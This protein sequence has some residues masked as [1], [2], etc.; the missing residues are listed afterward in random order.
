M[1]SQSDCAISVAGIMSFDTLASCEIGHFAAFGSSNNIDPVNIIR[2]LLLWKLSIA[3]LGY[4]LDGGPNS[5][6]NY[7]YVWVYVY[8]YTYVCARVC[9]CVCACARVCVC[10]RGVPTVCLCVSEYIPL[11]GYFC[12]TSCYTTIAKCWLDSD[13]K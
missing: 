11:C 3:L 10:A 4:C 9:V 12:Y 5:S 2:K 13:A 8:A 7:V 1:N 6:N